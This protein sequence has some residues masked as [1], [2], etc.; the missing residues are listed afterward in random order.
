MISFANALVNNSKII[1]LLIS[2]GEFDLVHVWQSFS[3]ILCDKSIIMDTYQSNHKL[4]KLFQD[5]R[6]EREFRMPRGLR[7]LLRI[8][9]E[10][11]RSQAAR[12]KIIEHHFHDGFTSQPFVGME[13]NV[14]PHGIAWM[15]K[16]LNGHFYDFLRSMPS[17]FDANGKS[18]KRKRER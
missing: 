4:Q 12:L 2:D 8:N 5:E 7:L 11:S 17:L 10:N 9:S 15:A 16:E 18:N 3:R 6:N 14:L 1:E 13:W